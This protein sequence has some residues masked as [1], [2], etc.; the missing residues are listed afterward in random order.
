VQLKNFGDTK[1]EK[2]RDEQRSHLPDTAGYVRVKCAE[3]K[4]SGYC[5]VSIKRVIVR[6]RSLSDRRI[7][8]IL[9]I[10]WSTVV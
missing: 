1:T 2:F 6:F 8:S 9:L 5:R 10:E 4:Y 3:G 7:S